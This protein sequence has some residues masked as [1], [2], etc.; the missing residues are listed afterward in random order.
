MCLLLT[1]RPANSGFALI[2]IRIRLSLNLI[3]RPAMGQTT[4]VS[5]VQRSDDFV[6][7]FQLQS[8][9]GSAPRKAI[10]FTS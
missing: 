8:G 2:S 10:D 4:F 3:V 5:F 6:L 9:I 1:G 7:T